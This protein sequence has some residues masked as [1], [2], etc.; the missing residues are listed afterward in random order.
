MNAVRRNRRQSVLGSFLWTAVSVAISASP[1]IA[2]LSGVSAEHSYF[3]TS[4]NPFTQSDPDDFNRGF[5]TYQNIETTTGGGDITSGEQD[6]TVTA[7]RIVAKLAGTT[8]AGGAIGSTTLELRFTL[9]DPSSANF[10]GNAV[11]ANQGI[12]GGYS[13]LMKHATD[14]YA[15]AF[16]N[17]SGNSSTNWSMAINN[18]IELTAGTYDLKLTAGIAGGNV[19]TTSNNLTV[20]FGAGVTQVGDYNGDGFI[21]QGDLDAVL[22]NWGADT[23]PP[24][25]SESNL[26]GGGPFDGQFS[27]NELDGVLLNWGSGGATGAGIAIPEPT[28]VVLLLVG[29]VVAGVGRA[30]R[31]LKE[32]E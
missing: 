9:T 10:S 12:T 21:G 8:E 3:L 18:P 27:Q 24:N 15:N 7:S 25:F 17:L 20:Q 26:P 28:S 32:S 30:N 5:F 11:G 31:V 6:I 2:Q 29:T 19:G 22:L 4:K 14:S 16:L 1:A 13:V 23:L